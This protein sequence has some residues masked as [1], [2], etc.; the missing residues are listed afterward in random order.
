MGDQMWSLVV[1]G[2]LLQNQLTLVLSRYPCCS[3]H[4]PSALPV[5][6]LQVHNSYLPE[7]T[8]TCPVREIL[9]ICEREDEELVC[10]KGGRKK[11]WLPVA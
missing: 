6:L 3:S 7:N 1:L 5:S 4:L 10:S 9:P 11:Q 8:L 2:V